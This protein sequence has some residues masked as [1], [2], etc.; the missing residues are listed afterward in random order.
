MLVKLSHSGNHAKRTRLC[1]MMLQL[2]EICQT[3]TNTLSHT[4]TALIQQAWEYVKE[5]HLLPATLHSPPVCCCQHNDSRVSL[6]SVQLCEQLVDCLL[7]LVITSTQT[8][9]TLTTNSINLINEDDARGLALG[10]RQRFKQ[11]SPSRV[12]G[13]CV[14]TCCYY[15]AVLMRVSDDMA[16]LL[17]REPVQACRVHEPAQC[18]TNVIEAPTQHRDRISPQQ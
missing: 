17:C 13:W 11:D 1:C 12:E 18:P 9:T 3:P 8:R 15:T 5:N 2:H 4:A 10:L 6:K 16:Q 14:S 7:T